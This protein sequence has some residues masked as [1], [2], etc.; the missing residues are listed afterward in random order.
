MNGVRPRPMSMLI[1]PQQYIPAGNGRGEG[2]APAAAQAPLESSTSIR[3]QKPRNSSRVL[4]DHTLGRTLGASSMGEVKLAY[5]NLTGEKLAIKILPRSQHIEQRDERGYADSKGGNEASVEDGIE[6]DPRDAGDALS[7]LLHH[8]YIRGMRELITY[9][10]HYCM[11][12]ELL[13][14]IICRLRERVSRRFSAESAPH[15]TI[16]TATIVH[17]DSKIENVLISQT[18]NIKIIDCGLSNLY[19]PIA[20]LST[21]CRPLYFAVLELLSTRVYTGPE[22][23]V[24]SLG[25]VLYV[26]V[27]GKVSFDNMSMPAIHAKIERGL[28]EYPDWLSA[29]DAYARAV[30]AWERRCQSAGR[31]AHG[32][33]SNASLASYYS[34]LSAS[35]GSGRAGDTPTA[36]PSK[37]SR[38]FSGFDFYRPKFLSS[39]SVPAGHPAA[40]ITT[41]VVMFAVRSNANQHDPKRAIDLTMR[42]VKSCQY[43]ASSFVF[44]STSSSSRC[45]GSL[46]S[47][48]SLS[49]HEYD[50]AHASQLSGHAMLE[51]RWLVRA[52]TWMLGQAHALKA[53]CDAVRTEP[54]R[55]LECEVWH[56]QGSGSH[57]FE[58]L[59]KRLQSLPCTSSRRSTRAWLHARLD[60][61]RGGQSTG[62]ELLFQA[63]SAH[64]V[65]AVLMS[66]TDFSQF[67][68]YLDVTGLD[69]AVVGHSYFYHTRKHTVHYI[70]PGVVQHMGDNALVSLRFLSDSPLPEFTTSYSR[71]TTYSFSTT[72]ALYLVLLASSVL[73]A[74]QS[75]NIPRA[76]DIGAEVDAIGNA[77]SAG[78]V[79]APSAPAKTALLR[80]PSASMHRPSHSLSQRPM[81]AS[82]FL[83]L[84]GKGGGRREAETATA[85]AEIDPELGGHSPSSHPASS[86]VREFGTLL[87]GTRGD[88]SWFSKLSNILGGPSAGL[89][90]D[91]A[92]SKSVPQS[93][94]QPICSVHRRAAAI[95]DPQERM[96]WHELRRSTV[97]T[98]TSKSLSVIKMDIRRVLDWIQ[99]Q[100]RETK[101]GFECLHAPPNDLS[102]V[103]SGQLNNTCRL[104]QLALSGANNYYEVGHSEGASVPA[105]AAIATSGGVRRLLMKKASKLLSV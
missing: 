57:R 66:D 19:S 98:T 70:Q 7:V 22:V 49:D 13:D 75:A 72:T 73:V 16:V 76:R 59:G 99:V 12:F 45:L 41:F 61:P 43:F 27:C 3:T 24:W 105:A 64:T 10:N 35:S 82:V 46:T 74:S 81:T 92:R 1:A 78:S 90:G 51:H 48:R 68:L 60:Q 95:L 50:A 53:L 11:V 38:H 37:K 102:S 85:G 77:P 2:H 21:F 18:G 26:L 55:Q 6:G 58:I 39:D 28:V 89:S 42:V 47:L 23:D 104:H 25:V 32:G 36:T 62:L 97:S 88:D 52:D 14:N 30:Q 56:Q 83:A 5:H 4:G 44:V 96:A 93:E 67:E 40:D 20:R 87:G 34:A 9:T 54:R 33:L 71:A 65:Y 15:S 31:N 101:S 84:G 63:T 29:D 103:Q 79:S 80:T 69:L 86:L 94:S 8:P 100:Y 17:R 91:G